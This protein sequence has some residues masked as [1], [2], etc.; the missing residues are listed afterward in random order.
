MDTIAEK[1]FQGLTSS[2][3]EEF[4]LLW[5]AKDDAERMK[6]TVS[7]IKATL[8]DAESKA[9]NHHQVS[10]W[11]E[12]LKDVL[13]DA[14][15][16]LDDLSSEA[17]AREIM[18]RNKI[19]KKVRIFFSA[20][21]QVVYNLKMGHKMREINKR[22]DDIDDDRKKL[23][24]MNNYPL[25]LAPGAEGSM[26]IVTTRSET[27]GKIMGT[28]PSIMLK[29]LD[30]ER[31]WKLFCKIAFE[32]GK[33][34]TNM[35][36]VDIA[37]EIVKRCKGVPLAIRTIGRLLYSRTL[38]ETARNSYVSINRKEEE[39]INVDTI[40]H[41]SYYS[42]KYVPSDIPT[43]IKGD[44]LRSLIMI[45]DGEMTNNS[46][47]GLIISNLKCLRVLVLQDVVRVLPKSIGNL[48]HLR[49]LHFE[50]GSIW[51]S[52]V[53]TRLHNL[54]TLKLSG[55]LFPKFPRGINK[56]VNLR[57]L[58]FGE[59][60]HPNSTLHGL[61]QLT[62]LQTLTKFVLHKKKISGR[63]G[64]GGIS[65]LGSLN[66]LRGCLKLEWLEF[67]RDY[68]E[69]EAASARLQEKQ[70]LQELELH[71]TSFA[72][73]ND[74]FDPKDE[75]ILEGLHPPHT[76]KRL[77]ISGFCGSK[78]PDW[79]GSLSSLMTLEILDCRFLTSLPDGLRNLKCLDTLVIDECPRGLK[80]RCQ[81]ESGDDW[82]KIAHIRNRCINQRYFSL[83]PLLA[84]YT[85]AMFV[86]M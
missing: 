51:I 86:F 57:H 7:A 48:K 63:N 11:L 78:L 73:Q 36:V 25:D 22:L 69:E 4:K 34:P 71:W 16:L 47:L 77:M 54:Q 45:S 3:L 42:L 41:L 29:G 8:L 19:A 49:Y 85:I 52:R 12:R 31:S 80:E 59:Y 38:E 53:I 39:R 61:G 70:H 23:Q 32:E 2:A 15:D 56:L 64:I 24:L 65:E 62:S 84:F 66:N 60:C 18:T 37:K 46:D 76:I 50:H 27:V 68:N 28:F 9:K 13:Y 81:N 6:N 75:V 10:I 72:L 17:L 5:N 33:E 21:N 82:P 44:K 67:L 40:R 55:S 14:D 26:I 30:E 1:V 74:G 79:I 83:T 35:E 58:E 43:G 20:S